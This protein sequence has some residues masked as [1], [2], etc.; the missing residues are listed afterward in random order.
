MRWICLAIATVFSS[1]ATAADDATQFLGE[2]VKKEDKS[3][4]WKLKKT[5]ESNGSKIYT[6]SLTSQTWQGIPW[7][8]DLQIFVPKNAKPQS[9]MVLWNQ[10]GTAG[11]ESLLG[12]AISEKVGAPVAFL[13]GVPKQPL[14]V[15]A[16]TKKLTTTPIE[17][18]QQE[19]RS[20]GGGCSHRPHL[21]E[22]PRNQGCQL[23]AA[24][25]DG[26]E[27]GAGDGC[28]PSLRQ[29]RVEVRG[30][31]V[32]YHRGQQTWLDELAHCREQVTNG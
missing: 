31:G 10:G 32:R 6:F 20:I 17:P 21:R 29:G 3:F 2:Y 27:C 8:H 15:D 22:I 4:A 30:E 24:V 28:H 14:Y 19:R 1:V 23:A 13:Y 11:A 5:E 26:E 12:L 16:T 7:E 25:P 9:T 18:E